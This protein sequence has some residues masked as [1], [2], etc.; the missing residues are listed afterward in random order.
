MDVRREPTPEELAMYDAEDLRSL[1]HQAVS[2]RRQPYG[3][4][5]RKLLEVAAK[6]LRDAAT[7]VRSERR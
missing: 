7:A 5:T 3:P 2:Q 6:A 4:R 1:A